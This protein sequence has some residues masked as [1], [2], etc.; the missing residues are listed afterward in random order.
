MNSLLKPELRARDGRRQVG[1]RADPQPRGHI[2]AHADR[3]SV[4]ESQRPAH[5]DAA[6]RQRRAEGLLAAD[7]LA[8]QDLAGD[9]PGV[10]GVDV[11]L[12]GLERVEE[13]L[14][15]SQLAEVGRAGPRRRRA[16]CRAI[17]PRITDSVNTFDP[18]R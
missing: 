18:T 12:A 15:P 3:I 5:A 4:T 9:R 14:R 17:S 2:F 8:G 13:D 7:V 16:S 1:E 11:Q 10:F 6:L